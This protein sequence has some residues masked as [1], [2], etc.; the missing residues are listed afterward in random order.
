MGPVGDQLLQQVLA[1]LEVEIEA[2][3][4]HAQHAGQLFDVQPAFS[5]RGEEIQRCPQPLVTGDSLLLF[6]I[7]RS[8]IESGSG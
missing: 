4:C 8:I 6:T 7:H 2:A 3:F 1:V 5:I